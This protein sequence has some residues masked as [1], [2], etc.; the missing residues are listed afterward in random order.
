MNQVF[1][2]GQR[3]M[4]SSNFVWNSSEFRGEL[5]GKFGIVVEVYD[6]TIYWIP[7]CIGKKISSGSYQ[8]QILSYCQKEFRK[9]IL[10]CLV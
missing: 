6:N 8:L 10:S 1:Y 4:F 5:H 2:P 3:V 7:D 9:E